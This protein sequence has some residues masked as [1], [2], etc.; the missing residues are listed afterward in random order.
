MAA[1][2]QARTLRERI[3]SPKLEYAHM[4]CDILDASRGYPTNEEKIFTAFCKEKNV[5]HSLVLALTLTHSLNH[6]ANKQPRSTNALYSL[7]NGSMT[8]Y[9]VNIKILT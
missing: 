2:K 1:S 3:Y 9:E 8:D 4:T 6:L 5:M 7:I